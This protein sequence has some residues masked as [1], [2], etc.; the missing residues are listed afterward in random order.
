VTICGIQNNGYIQ[1]SDLS[2]PL[3]SIKRLTSLKQTRHHDMISFSHKRIEM[4]LEV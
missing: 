2:M 4:F 1:I 3:C